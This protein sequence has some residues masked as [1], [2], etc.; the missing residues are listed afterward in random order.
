M[1]QEI[2]INHDAETLTSA[3]GVTA[4]DVAE[5]LTNSIKKFVDDDRSKVSVLSEIL[6]NNVDY[7]IILLLAT[8]QVEGLARKSAKATAIEGLLNLLTED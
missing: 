4:K 5:Q 3:F 1:K 6:H 8:E 2:Q 7:K